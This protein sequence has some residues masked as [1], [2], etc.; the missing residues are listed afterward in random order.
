MATAFDE[1][2][3]VFNVVW[4]GDAFPYLQYFV[5]SQIAQSTAQFRF[6]VNGCPPDQ[7]EAMETAAAR[8]PDRIVEVLEVSES[9]VAHG[10]AL[11]SVRRCRH[12]GPLFAAI[13][14]D[15][16]ANA[17]F[18]GELLA[19]LEAGPVA[20]SSG[21]EVWSATNVVPEGSWGVAGEHFYDR[22]GFTFG[23]PHLVLYRRDALDATCE[24]WGVSLGSA[25]PE[26]GADAVA[27][28]EEM[29]RR[30]KVYDTGK[31]VNI[32]LQSEGAAVVQHELDQ[33]VHI[34]GVAHYLEP[35]GRVTA[36]DGSA[37]PDW[38]LYETVRDRYVIAQHAAELLRSICDG[39]P[40]PTIPMGT[41]AAVRAKLELVHRE[42]VDLMARH[43][44]W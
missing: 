42:V 14:P 17:P 1:R 41:D 44:G 23:G 30:F 29:G 13:D 6:V 9:L 27:R 15:I 21:T 43:R 33:V 36:A 16:K 5:A 7:R 24:R 38:A 40:A 8:H 22:D 19:V 32:L 12:D 2:D 20:V 31:I 10:V 26:L 18:V 25:G 35:T 4:T 37:E 28:L 11:E 3:V 39:G 34:G